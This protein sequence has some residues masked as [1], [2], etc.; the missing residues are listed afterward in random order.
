MHL[1]PTSCF[2]ILRAGPWEPIPEKNCVMC[3]S[4]FRKRSRARRRRQFFSF[5]LIQARL[6]ASQSFLDISMS[7]CYTPFPALTLPYHLSSMGL[8]CVGSALISP[9]YCT[10]GMPCAEFLF[11]FFTEFL[12][13]FFLFV[14]SNS[15]PCYNVFAAKTG[16]HD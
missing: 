9:L 7:L 11:H 13:H 8:T 6:L 2:F 3:A 5:V 15:G 4:P 10:W 14:D 16:R 1:R 12:F